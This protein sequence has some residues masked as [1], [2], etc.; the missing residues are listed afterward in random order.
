MTWE[1][2]VDEVLLRQIILRFRKG[3][4]TQRLATVVFDDEDYAKVEAGMSRT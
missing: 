1:R 2:S 4:K 3:V